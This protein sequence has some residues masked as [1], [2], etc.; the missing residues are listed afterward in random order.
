MDYLLRYIGAFPIAVMEAKA[1]SCAP[2]A[3]LEQAKRYAHDLGMPFAY[4]TNGHDIV[5]YLDGLRAQ[6]AELKRLNGALLARA[7]GG[8]Y[9]R[10]A[11]ESRN[12]RKGTKGAKAFVFQIAAHAQRHIV[13][14]LDSV[15]AQVT[16]LKRL[17]AESAA[18]L[19]RLSGAVQG[20]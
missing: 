1:K 6:M 20:V 18:E 4:A 2:D 19:E 15:Q 17:Q 7:F 13:E 12:K 11:F 3:G 14:Y 5:E 16:E 10:G 9:E 8:I